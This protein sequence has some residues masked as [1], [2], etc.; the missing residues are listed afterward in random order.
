MKIRNPLILTAFFLLVPVFAFAATDTP[1]FTETATDVPTSTI[2]RTSTITPTHTI[3]RTHTNTPTVTNTHTN[4][5]TA[6]PTFTITPTFTN[7]PTPQQDVYAY[8]N[9]AAY[10]DTM[11]V[12][13]PS[14]FCSAPAPTPCVDNNFKRVIITIY[15]AN[16]DYV[17][18]ITDDFPNGFTEFDITKLARGTYIY[19]VLVRYEDDT[20]DIYK[21]KRFA[22]IK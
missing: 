19:K 20:E 8:P 6:S 4:S 10:R 9:P 12:A 1:T 2:T 18:R 22:I 17:S 13:Y 21:Y 11:F 5:P 14:K 15:G 16:G 7:S 3:S